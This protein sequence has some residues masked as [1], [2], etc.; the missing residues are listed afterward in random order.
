MHSLQ[1]LEVLM[2]LFSALSFVFLLVAAVYAG[3][4]SKTLSPASSPPRAEEKPVIDIFHGTKV[5]DNYRWLEDG[6]NPE[7]QKWVEQEMA[8]TRRILDPLPGRDA[9]NKRLTA[10]LSIGSVSPPML[11]GRHYFYTRRE[12]MQN[13]PVLY[14]RDSLNGPD[15]VLVDANK[16]SADGTIALDWYYPSETGKYVAYG[17]SPS[18]SEMSTLHIIETK[19]G[20]ILPDTIERT[21]AA[22]V[23]WKRDNS[24]FYY[25]R[26]PKKG[27]VPEGQE[28][29]N[30]HVFFHLLGTDPDTDDPVFGEGR[31]AEDWPSVSLSNDGRWLLINV[32]QGWAKSELFLKDLKS[33]NAPTRLTTGKNF[34]Y[35]A[36]VYEGRVYIT[37]NEDAPRYRVF[38]TDAGNFEH[39]AWKE[40]IPQT[41]AVL[42]GAAVFGGKLFAQYE[43]DAS[44]QLKIFDLDGKKLTDISLPA[45][46][47]VFG[48]S[49]RWD[50]DE[51]F[52]AFHSFTVPP[53][54]YRVDL[55]L[56][57]Y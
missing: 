47:S 36:D 9:I 34:L 24:G 39:D 55:K 20:R 13:Q 49:G 42:Q 30:R 14:V 16:L 56:V 41:D 57:H 22:S 54:V 29:Y 43:Q 21:R 32:S 23:A 53:S 48:T 1:C 5:L 46:G 33:N 40:I 25:T 35:S 28:M 31:D 17:T 19:T 52:F 18:G 26:Y 6:K 15:R 27:D 10:L 51:A 8:Y 2:R 45:I 50:R 11:A 38:I 37:T 44:S 12:G 7:T 3:D 4:D